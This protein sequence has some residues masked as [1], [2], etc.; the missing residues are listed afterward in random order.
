MIKAII[1][2]DEELGRAALKNLI[3]KYCPDI[4]VLG[5]AGNVKEAKKLVAEMNPD[6]VFLDIEMPGG[7]GFELLEQTEGTA[8]FSVIFTTAYNQYAVKAFKYSAVDYLLKPINIDE[9]INAVKKLSSPGEKKNMR[10]SLQH[11]IDSYGK[12]GRAHV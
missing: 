11:F 1:V 10:S 9:L 2:E 8:N 4:S 5:E 6:L 7:S 3:H 12:I